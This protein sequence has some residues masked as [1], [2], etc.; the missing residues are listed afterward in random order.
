MR[1]KTVTLIAA[2]GQTLAVCCN[3]YYLIRSLTGSRWS[4]DPEAFITQP[5]Y[6]L[7]DAAVVVFLFT[8]YARQKA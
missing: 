5:I 4:L 3:I 7:A 2:I 6:V 1:L 8:L